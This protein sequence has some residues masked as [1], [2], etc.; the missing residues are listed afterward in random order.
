[1]IVMGGTVSNGRNREETDKTASNSIGTFRFVNEIV[2]G[3]ER[4]RMTEETN[5]VL[6]AVSSLYYV[7]LY[8]SRAM[9]LVS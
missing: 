8:L 6:Q 5:N 1:M 2:H 9:S 3:L 7:I 4:V